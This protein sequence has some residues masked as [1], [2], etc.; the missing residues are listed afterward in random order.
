MPLESKSSLVS[1]AESG[2]RTLHGRRRG[3]DVDVD[4][5]HLLAIGQQLYALGLQLLDA[6]ALYLLLLAELLHF[7]HP[8]FLGGLHNSTTHTHR[9]NPLN[10]RRDKAASLMREDG[11]PPNR[12]LRNTTQHTDWKLGWRGV[13]EARSLACNAKIR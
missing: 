3:A 5:L 1:L 11:P 12:V 10:Q 8:L 7:V 6:Q 9:A 2:L 13:N 4:G